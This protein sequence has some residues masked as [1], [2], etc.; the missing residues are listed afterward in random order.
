[1]H[2]LIKKVTEMFFNPQDNPVV[3]IVWTQRENGLMELRSISLSRRHAGYAKRN[4]E[5]YEVG[6][7][8]MVTAITRVWIEECEANHVYGGSVSQTWLANAKMV[9]PR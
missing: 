5:T 7:P 2:A 8:A 6:H 9:K 4:I 1:M 3:W